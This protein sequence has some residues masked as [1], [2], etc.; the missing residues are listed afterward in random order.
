MLC[1]FPFSCTCLCANRWSSKP[2]RFSMRHLVMLLLV[3]HELVMF[4]CECPVAW[5]GVDAEHAAVCVTGCLPPTLSCCCCRVSS[6][7]VRFRCECREIMSTDMGVC[8]AMGSTQVHT[9]RHHTPHS[10]HVHHSRG[11]SITGS[12]TH[13]T[14]H[15]VEASRLTHDAC[16]R[17]IPSTDTT[18][19]VHHPCIL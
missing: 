9:W 19:A 4:R 12:C 13:T 3:H 5:C 11:V 1:V 6:A 10:P 8:H 16:G 7:G 14:H 2:S 18:C 17:I 15:S